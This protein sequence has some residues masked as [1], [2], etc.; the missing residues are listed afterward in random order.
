MTFTR[1]SWKPYKS[2]AG[3]GS[4]SPSP[5]THRTQAYRSRD[6]NPHACFRIT[7]TKDGIDLTIEFTLPARADTDKV[8][9]SYD[10]GALTVRIPKMEVAKGK[11]ADITTGQHI[12]FRT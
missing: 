5:S 9:A 6:L 2:V 3:A 11:K 10:V 4:R 1:A 7:R 8:E 12:A